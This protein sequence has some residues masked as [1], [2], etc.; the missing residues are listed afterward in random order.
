MQPNEPQYLR[1][2]QDV[3]LFVCNKSVLLKKPFLISKSELRRVSVV[4]PEEGCEF[5]MHFFQ[6]LDGVFILCHVRIH[7]CDAIRPT[8]R[9]V[10]VI[11]KAKEILRE[12]PKITVS[13]L[14]D[15]LKQ[16]HEVDVDTM[17]V[18]LALRDVKTDPL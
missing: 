8:I 3:K 1:T 5:A 12:R 2:K 16:R 15:C 9:L 11:A 6:R 18:S 4:C 17:I 14:R 13:E 7:T 10:W